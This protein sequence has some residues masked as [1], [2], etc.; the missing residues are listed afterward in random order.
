[1][2]GWAFKVMV[3]RAL[4]I[5]I[6]AAGRKVD[7]STRNDWL[8]DCRSIGIDPDRTDPPRVQG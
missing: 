1:M 2:K 7:R 4:W 5:L 3:L 8:R 6:I